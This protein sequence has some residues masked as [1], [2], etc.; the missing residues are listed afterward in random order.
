MA[1]EKTIDMGIGKCKIS[2]RGA[3]SIK[4]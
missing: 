4:E 3:Q 2:Q 1:E